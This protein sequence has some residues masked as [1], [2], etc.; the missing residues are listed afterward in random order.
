[1]LKNIVDNIA[2][3]NELRHVNPKLKVI[4]AISLLLI[5]VFSNSI[6]VPLI[7]ALIMTSLTIFKAKVPL[8][9]YLPL[10]GTPVGFGILTVV[11]MAII[12]SGV[13]DKLFSI[14]IFGYNISLHEYG[15]NMGLL[16]FSRMLGGVAS[17]L[18]LVLTTPMT[19]L[20]YVLKELRVP[21]SILDI[22][23]M[24]Y[25]YIFV[26]LDETIRI[27]NAQKTR[28]GYKDLKTTYKSLGILAAN[29]FITSWDRGERLFTTMNSRGYNG[30]LKLLSKIESPNIK[31]VL[32][33]AVFDIL[34]II[35]LYL[36]KDFKVF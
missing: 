30:N 18:F 11:L 25:R 2:H 14:D 16:V 10:I 7:I 15:V 12:Y 5:C 21:S 20:F 17:T 23:M 24:M 31:Y 22:A 35:L 1:M 26:L 8:K 3:N 29:L 4:F 32:L 13:G 28:L 36:T 34:L 6:I 19:D 33:I 9:I 27:E